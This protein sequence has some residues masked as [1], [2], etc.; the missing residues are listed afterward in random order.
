GGQLPADALIRARFTGSEVIGEFSA[1]HGQTRIRVRT[2]THAAPFSEPMRLGLT[3]FSSNS[4]NVG[5]QAEFDW[6]RV[7]EGSEGDRSVEC[8]EPPTCLSDE[9]D[10]SGLDTERWSFLHPTTP[11][12]GDGAPSVADGDLVLPLGANSL[13]DVR[14]G[15]IALV[16]QP[17]PDGDFTMEAQDRKST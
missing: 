15:P 7:H 9:F 11:T 3:A 2:A 14:E 12:N 4:G 13:N 1:D 5:N 6:F 17:L 8:G 10:G 16:G